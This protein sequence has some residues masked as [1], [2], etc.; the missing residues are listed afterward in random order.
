KP[1]WVLTVHKPDG[2]S[3]NFVGVKHLLAKGPVSLTNANLKDVVVTGYEAREKFFEWTEVVYDSC[4]HS[5]TLTTQ[6]LQI[7]N[8]Y[9]FAYAG[10]T[11]AYAV[12]GGCGI[13][14]KGQWIAAGCDTYALLLDT[15]GSG[16]F[17]TLRLGRMSPDSVPAWLNK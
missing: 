2:W 4:N 9:G 12:S 8:V 11:F 7:K 13:F 1:D 15:T 10:R 14:D 6:H 17:D 5:T 3:T 16:T